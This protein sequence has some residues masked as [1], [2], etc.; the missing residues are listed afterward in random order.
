MLNYDRRFDR[1]INNEKI[2]KAT[3]LGASDFK[4]VA[5]GLAI[6]LKKIKGEINV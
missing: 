1:V 5:E 4:T 3:G 2:L 6:E